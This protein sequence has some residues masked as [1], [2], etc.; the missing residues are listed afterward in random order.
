[1]LADKSVV[2]FMEF[3][4]ETICSN[5]FTS[6]EKDMVDHYHYIHFPWVER[7]FRTLSWALITISPLLVLTIYECH[8]RSNFSSEVTFRSRKPLFLTFR[9]LHT[10][11]RRFCWPV[12][13][14]VAPMSPTFSPYRSHG[15]T[16]WHWYVV[17]LTYLQWHEHFPENPLSRC[18]HSPFLSQMTC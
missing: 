5:G 16:G 2:H 3:S 12:S 9:E 11:K 1:M 10:S 17:C 4:T 18:V 14:H 8:S 15:A 13:I 6:P 7:W